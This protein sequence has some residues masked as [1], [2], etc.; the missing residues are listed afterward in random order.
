MSD[1]VGL[2]Y[3]GVEFVADSSVGEGL[4]DGIIASSVTSSR[5]ESVWTV[6]PI[7]DYQA[8]L[9]LEPLWNKLVDEANAEHPF[10]RHE[11]VRAWWECF[12]AGQE[13]YIL[14][15][16]ADRDPVAI[17]PLMS[18]DGRLCGVPVRQLQFIWNVYAERF[19]FI[20]GRWPQAAYRATLAHLLSRKKRWDLLLL[21]Q[22]PAGSPSLTE[23][24]R[25]DGEHGIRVELVRSADS[26]YLP[27][28]GSWESY[29]KSL[30]AKHRSNLRNRHKRLRDLGS[31]SLEI[32]TSAK[33]LA[34]A[35]EDGFDLEAAAW[36]GRA[37]SAIGSCP[38]VRRFYT[39]LAR[40]AAER[41]SLRICFL[42]LNGE[43][44]AFG[45]FLQHG[46]KLYL[47]KPGY[48]PRYACYSP[49]TLL[50]NLV[51]RDAFDRQLTEVDFLGLADP[52]KL[53][54]TKSLRTHYWLYLFPDRL[55]PRLL[56]WIRFRLQPALG[57]VQVLRMLRDF[58]LIALRSSWWRCTCLVTW[59][60]ARDP[61]RSM[62][63]PAQSVDVLWAR[64]R[65]GDE[66][67]RCS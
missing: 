58:A 3:A 16:K 54:W 4:V 34:Q 25:L 56:H 38:E 19:D 29:C 28:T 44:I 35:L 50:S 64:L 51:L 1:A 21:H 62:T 63:I 39:Q 27:I 2:S 47:L 43:R 11:W 53:Q 49:S 8:F 66:R 22:L 57:Q 42:T 7:T 6:E 10:V 23:M 36:K 46:N 41:G 5:T 15:V 40:F 9:D 14:L 61:L 20:V 18:C 45:Y 60:P 30:D 52:W 24:R 65:R 17:V 67:G 33:G 13:L 55:K 26:P 12:G 32:V 31:V 37:G 59:R 48:D